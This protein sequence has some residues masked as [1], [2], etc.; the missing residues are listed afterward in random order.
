MG[1]GWWEPLFDCMSL[2]YQVFPVALLGQM[3]NCAQQNAEDLDAICSAP[4]NPSPDIPKGGL[5]V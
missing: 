5:L 4:F 1:Q 2:Y 3:L